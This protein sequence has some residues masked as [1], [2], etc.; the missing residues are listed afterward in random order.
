MRAEILARDMIENQNC[1]EIFIDTIYQNDNLSEYLKKLINHL[2]SKCTQEDFRDAVKE[3]ENEIY[4]E[5]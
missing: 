5:F 1:Y 3:T 4:K 2:T